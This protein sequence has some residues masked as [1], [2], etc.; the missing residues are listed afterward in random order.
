MRRV[1]YSVRALS[2]LASLHEY[3]STRNP[4]AAHH[5]TASIARTIARIRD[6]PMLGRPTDEG[7]VYLIVEPEY[8]YRIFYAISGGEIY[9]IRI[10][11]SGQT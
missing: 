5:I 8:R 3:L 10:L 9:V 6:L 11:R 1:Q 7:N 2:Q 4:S